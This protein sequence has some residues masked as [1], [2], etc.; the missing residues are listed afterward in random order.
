MLIT[1]FPCLWHGNCT[2][3]TAAG[4]GSG[5]RPEPHPGQGGR[6]PAR[7]DAE[8]AEKGGNRGNGETANGTTF[9]PGAPGQSTQR[10]AE[11]GER[12][13]GTAFTA[14]TAENGR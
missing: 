14:E 10:K 9:N 8:N 6:S 7:E 12:R 1:I 3:F 13:N 2:A 11:M 4:H 5:P